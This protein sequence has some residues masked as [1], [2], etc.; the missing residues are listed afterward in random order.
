MRLSVS[1]P[2]RTALAIVTAAF[3]A[4]YSRYASLGSII[5]AFPVA[6]SGD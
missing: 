3:S 6:S 1:I 5:T 2:A 4:R